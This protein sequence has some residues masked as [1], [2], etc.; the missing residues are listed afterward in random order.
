V[1]KTAIKAMVVD[2]EGNTTLIDIAP[3]Q[4]QQAFREHC[5]AQYF[6]HLQL[7][8]DLDIWVD[9]EGLLRDQPE[10]NEPVTRL[11]NL[12]WE[13]QGVDIPTGWPP[14]AGKALLTGGA[15]DAGETLS[16]SEPVIEQLEGHFASWREAANT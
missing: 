9:D 14:L 6:D 8:E 2:L 15:N 1:T 13:E 16:L 3:G 11:R 4:F 5:E 12:F 7:A 10:F